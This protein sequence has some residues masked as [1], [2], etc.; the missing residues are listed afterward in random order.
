[1]AKVGHEVVSIGSGFGHDVF[2]IPQHRKALSLAA[3]FM[4]H[5]TTI[6]FTLLLT[7][8]LF[9]QKRY[10]V[11]ANNVAVKQ[12]VSKVTVD[13]SLKGNFS[14][15]KKWDYPEGV[16]KDDS[17]GE[18]TTDGSP[19]DT[20]HLFYTANCSTN[21]QG[22]Y[23]IRYCYAKKDKNK[24]TLTF[25]D[26][27]P[28]YASEFYVYIDTTNFWCDAETIYPVFIKGQK[29]SCTIIKQKLT[30]DKPKYSKGDKIKGFIEMDFIETVSVPKKAVQ[31]RKYLFK[32]YFKTT[33][34]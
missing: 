17:T 13:K 14:F 15:S 34:D 19:L 12:I 20:T 27:L 22:G 32:G 26:G 4:R 10:L 24:I 31:K 2:Q 6:I 16:F 8:T 5:L 7:Q 29:K 9:G 33:L 1:M 21:V 23:D 28:A 25:A 30:V 11:G 18:F 3:I